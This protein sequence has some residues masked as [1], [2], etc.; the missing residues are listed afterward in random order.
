MMVLD[1]AFKEITTRTETF[2]FSTLEVECHQL[3]TLSVKNTQQAH[4]MKWWH[5]SRNLFMKT[6]DHYPQLD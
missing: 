2:G 5:K 4:Q 6:A 1:L 3:M